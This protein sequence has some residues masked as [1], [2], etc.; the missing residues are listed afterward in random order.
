MFDY[1]GAIDIISPVVTWNAAN[2]WW[3]LSFNVSGFSGFFVG[4]TP[5]ANL[6]LLLISFSG[7]REANY[8]VLKW[9]TAN[10]YNNR[11]FYVE[12]SLDGIHYASIGFVNSLA[13]N[14]TSTASL[15]YTY[16]DNFLQG[17]KQ[18][19]RLRQVDFDG[20]SKHSN[21]VIIKGIRPTILTMNLF[22]NPAHQVVNV[23]LET[24]VREE[25]TLMMIDA[26]GKLVRKQK[27]TIDIGS[28]VVPIEISS[29]ASGNYTIILPGKGDR[30]P[31]SIQFIKY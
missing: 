22:P 19:Y 11:G 15:H 26:T 7:Y 4:S 17:D 10:E 14:G 18:F 2:S 24:P 21:V 27:A 29:L 28:N 12:R 23:Q 9:T 3:E 8:N 13:P 30:K 6:P 1:P 5:T 25:V 31:L 16:I 20:K